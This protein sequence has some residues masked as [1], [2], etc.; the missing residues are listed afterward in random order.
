MQA[1]FAKAARPELGRGPRRPRYWYLGDARWA[2][3]TSAEE[4][5]LRWMV[6]MLPSGSMTH[7]FALAVVAEQFWGGNAEGVR[8]D[9]RKYQFRGRSRRRA[10]F[11][12]PPKHCRWAALPWAWI[13]H[14]GIRAWT[15]R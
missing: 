12:R 15:R 5:T 10:V 4:V 8:R 6:R 2:W 11:R 13:P 3:P 14:G 9:M 1:A 7:C